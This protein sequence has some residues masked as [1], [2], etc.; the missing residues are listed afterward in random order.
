MALTTQIVSASGERLY[1]GSKTLDPSRRLAL[2]LVGGAGTEA[3]WWELIPDSTSRGVHRIRHQQRGEFLYAGSSR[4]DASRRHAL[5]WIGSDNG[6]PAMR[7]ELIP[8]G[9]TGSFLIRN[10]KLNEYLYTGSSTLDSRSRYAL[11]WVG[12]ANEDPAMMWC[13]PA[14]QPPV[15]AREATH[16]FSPTA[17]S[18]LSESRKLA[19]R[20]ACLITGTEHLLLGLLQESTNTA[21]RWLCEAASL[22]AEQLSAEAMAVVASTAGS[23]AANHA[24]FSTRSL[25]RALELAQALARPAGTEHLLLGLLLVAQL[26]GTAN[27]ATTVCCRCAGRSLR[28]LVA[29]LQAAVGVSDAQVSELHQR[30][31]NSGRAFGI[32]WSA[33][34][35]AAV[36]TVAGTKESAEGAGG[37]AAMAQPLVAAVAAAGGGVGGGGGVPEEISRPQMPP[38]N[39]R[40]PVHD[41]HWVWPNLLCG[42][43][44]GAMERWDLSALLA[45]GVDTFVCLQQSYTEYGCAD[46]RETVRALAPAQ[47]VRF[48]HCP[49]PDFGVLSNDSLVAL[50]AELQKELAEERNHMLYIHCMGGHG[51]TGTVVSNLISAVEGVD[52]STAMRTLQKCHRGRGCRRHCS[53]NMGAF[54]YY[55]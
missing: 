35:P 44:A 15:R 19:A 55:P 54:P 25:T 22:P 20:Q 47:E 49:V 23:S 11:T 5:T 36:T 4:L 26:D 14:L 24:K 46:Y 2:T 30:C 29:E 48:L 32:H 16:P 51:R 43:S 40:G 8:R 45:A 12:E 52:C 13:I 6:D 9:E 1:A 7:W 27:A 42:K 21:S 28:E 33:S 50:I 10:A 31:P 3:S 41:T 53:L 18:T 17:R 34:I 39:K 38:A 37:A